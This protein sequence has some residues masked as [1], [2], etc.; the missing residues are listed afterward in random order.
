MKRQYKEIKLEGGVF[1]IKNKINGKIL[2]LSTPNLK[3]VTGKIMALKN[4]TH[5]NAE[6]QSDWKNHGEESFIVEILE[7]I[8]QK[9]EDFKNKLEKIEKKWLEKLNPFG[10]R[11]YNMPGRRY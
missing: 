9:D 1:I 10:G 11:G 2:L 3:M 6:L 5:P 8:D 7:T 4:G